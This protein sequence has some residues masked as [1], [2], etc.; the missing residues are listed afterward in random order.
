[1]DLSSRAKQ[2]NGLI[3]G[4]SQNVLSCEPLINDN[5]N[6]FLKHTKKVNLSHEIMVNFPMQLCNYA[7]LA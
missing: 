1:M 7:G 3:Y 2:I 4:P 5:R 6:V